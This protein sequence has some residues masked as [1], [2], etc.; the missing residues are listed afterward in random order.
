MNNSD[1]NEKK[2][3]KIED[4]LQKLEW[5]IDDR[6]RY[7]EERI[8]RLTD[9]ITVWNQL[10]EYTI[11]SAYEKKIREINLFLDT[12]YYPDI[13]NTYRSDSKWSNDIPYTIN[14]YV[15]ENADFVR[16]SIENSTFLKN[17]KIFSDI[18]KTLYWDTRPIL[19][20]YSV[21]Y[22]LSFF[23][24]SI[25]IFP[26]KEKIYHHGLRLVKTNNPDKMQIKYHGLGGLFHRIVKTFSFIFNGSI[27]SDFLIDFTEM[28]EEKIELH[29]NNNIFSIENKKEKSFFVKDMFDLSSDKLVDNYRKIKLKM[30][31]TEMKNRYITS[32]ILLKNFI[33]IFTACSLARYYPFVWKNIY[34]GTKSGHFLHYKNA[35]E[36]IEDMVSFVT[37]E[38]KRLEQ[39]R[40]NEFQY[41]IWSF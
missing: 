16:L 34:E 14:S 33:L 39:K 19:S 21:S 5:K 15:F 27:F 3:K 1:N 38:L 29:P 11:P 7:L 36:N 2:I 6:D 17:A 30:I 13:V 23:I 37:Y 22:L 10:S 28:S 8:K 9:R 18:S 4:K 41:N 26:D 25:V 32:S 24:N 20:Y 35:I 31:H 12:T 40:R